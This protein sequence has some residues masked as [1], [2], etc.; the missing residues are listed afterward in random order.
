MNYRTCFIRFDPNGARR[1]FLAAEQA[2]WQD[3]FVTGRDIRPLVRRMGRLARTP[4]T[5]CRSMGKFLDTLD[6]RPNC[7]HFTG[8][9]G[10][11]S[12]HR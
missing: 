1:K 7:H 12:L 9:F 8:P 3:L 10:P 11:H 5:F 6:S 4:V 2:T